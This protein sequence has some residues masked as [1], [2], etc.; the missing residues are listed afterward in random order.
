MP[1]SFA[2]KPGRFS[3]ESFQK[4]FISKLANEDAF[5]ALFDL[6]PEIYFFIKDDVGRFV[7]MNPALLRALGL[8][9]ESEVIGRNDDDFFSPALAERYREEDQKVMAQNAPVVDQIW[10]VPNKSGVLNWYLS[11]KV[12][13]HDRLG[14]VIGI[15]GAMRDARSAGAVIGPYE[16]LKAAVDHLSRNFSQEIQITDLASMVHLSVSQF[17]RRFRALFQMPPMQYLIQLRIENACR[18]L[19]RSDDSIAEIAGRNGFY[20]QSAFTRHFRKRLGLTPS[21]YR[22]RY[23][24][25]A[26][27]FRGPGEGLPQS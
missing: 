5:G 10:F 25:D 3:A 21:Q 20:D 22:E 15:A 19:E 26:V 13:L 23:V 9:D 18:Q 2:P 7:R 11:S 12:P 8:S 1:P 24:V 17:E 4:H 16:D 6:L 27:A 14:N